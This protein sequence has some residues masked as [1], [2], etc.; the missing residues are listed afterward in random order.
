[1]AINWQKYSVVI[2]IDSNIALECLALEQLPWREIANS[3]SLL[4]L[5]APTVVQEV[6][7]KKNHARLG[8]HARRFNKTLRPLLTGSQTVVIRS[9]PAP[10]VEI[11]L[12]D[13]SPIDWSSLP[14]LDRDEADAKVAVQAYRAIGPEIDKRIVISHDIRPLYLARQL[15]LRVLQIG[16][17][18]LRPKEIS[19]AEKKAANLQRELNSIKS[20]EPK[21]EAYFE[22]TELTV[23]THRV[24]PLSSQERIEIRKTILQLHPMPVQERTH[25]AFQIPYDYDSS[26]ERRYAE[27]KREIVPLF[28]EQYERKLELNFGQV[29]VSFRLKNTGQVPAEGLLIR[30]T[31][32]GG[33]LNDRYVL[34]RPDGPL[35]P[36]PRRNHL[37]PLLNI[38]ARSVQPAKPG[39]HE[40]AVI[41]EPRRSTQVQ[42]S[43]EDFRH[44]Y[45]YEY[46]LVAWVDPHADGLSIE[47]TVTAS[48]LHGEVRAQINIAP[49]VQEVAVSELLDMKSMKFEKAPPIAL[50][51][52]KSIE[53]KKYDTVEFD[54]NDWDD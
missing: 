1:M 6:D 8:D 52:K 33:W 36:Q 38:H 27:W 35:S 50:L 34:A 37:N 16:D 12:A 44:G 23:K 10:E 24:I 3:G 19:E 47:G 46:K 22:S 29:E 32:S 7:S 30:I 51:Y 5:I 40:F 28:V 39:K 13:C 17:N 42:I 9:S 21:L 48:N 25:G 31:A 43:C 41:E 49:L 2:F 18:W 11:A 20:R 26:L 45:D 53:Q 54:N 4:V 14:D 15:G